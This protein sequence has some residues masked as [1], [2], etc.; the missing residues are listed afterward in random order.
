[1]L[2][3]A[4][5]SKKQK[6]YSE[7]LSNAGHDGD[8]SNSLSIADVSK[9]I[10][11]SLRKWMNK[12]NGQLKNMQEG[13]HYSLHIVAEDNCGNFEV[14]IRC[15]HCGVA[16]TLQQIKETFIM[17]NWYRHAKVCFTKSKDKYNQPVIHSFFSMPKSTTGVCN[18]KEPTSVSSMIL[19]GTANHSIDLTDFQ[20]K[21]DMP[22]A[23]DKTSTSSDANTYENNQVF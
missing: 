12:Q 6:P 23:A 20:S 18:S 21:S 13:Q 7:G 22:V 11:T 2:S 4:L 3:K 19:D 5:P 10:R 8:D 17:S 16:V 14:K 9:Q 1:M 15:L